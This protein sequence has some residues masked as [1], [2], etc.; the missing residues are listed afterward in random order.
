MENA[1]QLGFN[2]SIP[3]TSF[4]ENRKLV[5]KKDYRK[6]YFGLGYKKDIAGFWKVKHWGNE[7][8]ARLARLLLDFDKDLTIVTTGDIMDNKLSMM[9]VKRLL[10]GDSRFQVITE[11][12][13]DSFKTVKS[14]TTYIG[15]DTGMMHVASSMDLNVIGLFFMEHAFR[16]NR[17]WKNHQCCIEAV[18]RVLTPD[19]V[20]A[21]YLDT[22][23]EQPAFAK[24]YMCT[25]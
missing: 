5:I 19:E 16:K 8:Y 23:T 3:D 18:G 10:N 24:E 4:F 15:N 14:C 2:G 12:L 21:K 22:I 6:I 13:E 9:P 25:L 7:N 1:Y 20:F 17:P 11:K